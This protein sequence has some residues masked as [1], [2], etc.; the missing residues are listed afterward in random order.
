MSLNATTRLTAAPHDRH[1]EKIVDAINH[2]GIKGHINSD[3]QEIVITTM[4]GFNVHMIGK[5]AQAMHVDPEH[6]AI[7]PGHG[8]SIELRIPEFVI[9]K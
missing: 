3:G 8:G 6:I 9:G 7:E 5:F 1:L 2:S 4:K